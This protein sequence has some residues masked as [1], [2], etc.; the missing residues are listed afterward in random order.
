VLE[1]LAPL[2]AGVE[3]GPYTSSPFDKVW[4]FGISS[5]EDSMASKTKTKGRKA[6][7]K[8]KPRQSAKKNTPAAVKRKSGTI[9]TA[10]K[11]SKKKLPAKKVA[12]PKKAVAKKSAAKKAS[13]KKPKAL[14]SAQKNSAAKPA[15]KA[16]G[17]KMVATKAVAP[18]AKATD[19]AKLAKVPRKSA[20]QLKAEAAKVARLAAVERAK[21]AELDRRKR[22]LLHK[23]A[24]VPKNYQLSEKEPYMNAKQLGYFKNKLLDWRN[25]LLRESTQTLANLQ[26]G[27]PAEADLTDRASA[28]SERSLELRTRDRERKLVSKID[29]ALGRIIDGSYGFCEETDEPIGLKRLE[30]RPIAT[31]SIEAQERHERRERVY[32]DE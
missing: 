4:L 16:I 6:A 3:H 9:V 27:G 31:L 12:R 20:T 11:A 25:E 1:L 5:F 23:R 18:K 21:L 17:A 26:E 15:K 29:E 30:A 13:A 24:K 22:A 28:E 8:A 2:L 32:R 7:T 10:K 19:K 14:R